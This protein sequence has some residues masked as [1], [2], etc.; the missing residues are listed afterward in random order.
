MKRALLS[1]LVAVPLFAQPVL[2]LTPN[3]GQAGTTLEVTANAPLDPAARITFE[4]AGLTVSNIRLAPNQQASQFT[5]TIAPNA[6]PGPYTFIYDGPPSMNLRGGYSFRQPNA[7]TVL[8][9][10]QQQSQPFIREVRPPTV[11]AG[12]PPVELRVT[13][14][15]F[16]RGARLDAGPG[17]TINISSVTPSAITGRISAAANAPL[18]PRRV[19]VTNPDGGTHATDPGRLTV[20][21][22]AVQPPP[23]PQKQPPDARQLAPASITAGTMV[24]VVVTG[25]NFVQGL[26]IAAGNGVAA[27]V[28]AVTPT[29]INAAFSVDAN[30]APGPRAVVVTNPD[31]MSDPTPV[32]LTVV[33]K[34][35]PELPRITS[36]TPSSFTPGTTTPV[37]IT[38]ERFQP[39]LKLALGDG[40]TATVTTVT[41]TQI[42][43][44]FTVAAN[45]RPGAR[46]VVVTNPNG[47]SNAN[48]PPPQITVVAPA[49][50]TAP[51][52]RAVTPP[53]I[54]AGQTIQVVIAGENFKA[55]ATVAVGGQGVRFTASS[56]TANAING[57]MTA[58]ERAEPGRRP[59]TVTNPDRLS[60][61]PDPGAQITV[62]VEERVV[63]VIVSI[64][65]PAV[66]PGQTNVAISITGAGFQP[67]ATVAI[68]GSGI[69][70]RNVRVL[71]ASAISAIADVARTAEAGPRTVMVRNPDGS[72]TQAQ[73]PQP[74]ILV[75][76]P[77]PPPLDP[78]L[79]PRVELVTPRVVDPGTQ[80]VLT[81]QGANFTTGMTISLGNDVTIVGPVFVRSPRE[82]TV[83][84][85]ALPS[86]AAG[87]RTV[88]AKS[89]S[90]SASG[91]GSVLITSTTAPVA[92]K[93]PARPEKPQLATPAVPKRPLP[94][95]D[96]ILE[97]PLDPESQRCAPGS[98]SECAPEVL[99]LDTVFRWRETNPGIAD[100][101]K[102]EIID[103]YGKVLLSA[104]TKQR[105]Y[106][107][108]AALMASLP[109]VDA[110]NARKSGTP[111]RPKKSATGSGGV[112]VKGFT[113]PPL[114]RIGVAADERSRV[115]YVSTKPMMPGGG[116]GQASTFIDAVSAASAWQD[117]PGVAYWRVIGYHDERDITGK[118]SGNFVAVEESSEEGII[119]PLPPTGAGGCESALS[120]AN[121][122]VDSLTNDQVPAQ[123]GAP[124]MHCA[125]EDITLSGTIDLSRVP[126]DVGSSM[127]A[128]PPT[129]VKGKKA[130]EAIPSSVSFSN[131]FID[132]GDGTEPER[133]SVASTAIGSS[134]SVGLSALS[135]YEKPAKGELGV[136]LRHRYKKESPSGGYS[137]RI[138]SVSDPD[139]VPAYSVADAGYK[140]ASDP[141]GNASAIENAR[142]L[143][144][145]PSTHLIACAKV[146]VVEAPGASEQDGLHLVAAAVEWPSP[147]DATPE[148]KVSACA[149]A[150]RPRVRIDYWGQGRVRVS[151]LINGDATPLEQTEL[152]LAG[153]SRASG[154]GRRQPRIEELGVAL[155]LS[156]GSG[157]NTLVA[158]VELIDIP[159]PPAPAPSGGGK[160]AGGSKSLYGAQLAGSLYSLAEVNTTVKAGSPAAR[161]ITPDVMARLR[162]ITPVEGAP[163]TGPTEL[164]SVPRSYSIVAAKE[165][166]VC[167]LIYP[168]TLGDFAITDLTAL[169]EKGGRY[170]GKGTLRID[171]PTGSG[172][173]KAEYVPLS[174]ANWQLGPPKGGERR[175]TDGTADATLTTTVNPLN[176]AVK[177]TRLRL[178][179]DVA[180]VDGSVSLTSA[181]LPSIPGAKYPSFPFA[182]IPVAPSGD[183][184]FEYSTPL[185]LPLGC[186]GFKL[187][188]ERATID[189][190][191]KKG[192]SA[193]AA[194]CKETAS[195]AA[196][197][198][199]LVSG[200]LSAPDFTIG[201]A[202]KMLPDIPVEKWSFGPGGFS[203]E[204]HRDLDR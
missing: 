3:S 13:G 168:T 123:C 95:G 163:A 37:T 158:R 66:T 126:F 199:V 121:V 17:V 191:S 4:P 172:A 39:G 89:V 46:T 98:G 145:A 164:S 156:A 73:Q 85:L 67:G 91:P 175:V 74:R 40:V 72:S 116:V 133:L 113:P 16:E 154:E 161:G 23:T 26:R 103:P 75:A 30:A 9:R 176:F 148:P 129:P 192:E 81:L 96:I 174:F 99:T 78:R 41:P 21:A 188:I 151:W 135:N 187:R 149:E 79:A 19:A 69:T 58:E 182:G 97:A 10:Q 42:A 179:R 62:V 33:G 173:T 44:T 106:R 167:R 108:N 87:T 31:G 90:G 162:L 93:Q 56:I 202:G 170:S 32:Q 160:T 70:L 181:Q 63:P 185:D 14:L 115:K 143:M 5:L 125:G 203:A 84:V 194:T 71:D 6:Q 53:A 20:I 144:S 27:A 132:W 68:S 152:T 83:T 117:R 197:T 122:R 150:L 88:A 198:G 139:R 146:T 24:P 147:Y 77:E 119:L 76:A 8:P 55:G 136:P 110:G 140:L 52:V 155:P 111:R 25:E 54:N 35:A 43:A 49:A 34:A 193:S 159:A 1:L 47:A 127:S 200:T 124:G 138:F 57:T 15:R 64:T 61:P 101:F 134:S 36:I 59:I 86:V 109:V 12:A 169:E 104:Q 128:G 50:P 204:L 45:A 100:Y 114:E 177:F 201:S 165:G 189:F 107:M 141:R 196:W 166:E 2:Q 195:G 183:L 180:M 29:Q 94:E 65:P 137:I 186:S 51:R 157:S 112:L 131:V 190:S 130:T 18:G 80:T 7:F 11:V 105:H 28:T 82:A 153:V 60:S 178:G 22:A 102:L 171:F 118:R 38:G 48:Q 184:Y 142:K 92:V 120:S